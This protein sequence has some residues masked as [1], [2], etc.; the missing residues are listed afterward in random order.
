MNII[1]ILK[2]FSLDNQVARIDI[3]I[4]LNSIQFPEIVFASKE[5]D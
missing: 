2:I 3:I 5:L 4:E 1:I